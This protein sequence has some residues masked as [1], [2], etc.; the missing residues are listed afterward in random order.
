MFDFVAMKVLA[1]ASSELRDA[2]VTALARAPGGP[3]VGCHPEL[4]ARSRETG[5]SP[6]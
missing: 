1:N 6:M 3:A 5:W 2:L 4:P